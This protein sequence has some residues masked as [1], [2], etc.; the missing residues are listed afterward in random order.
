MSGFLSKIRSA[1]ADGVS[2]RL[3]YAQIYHLY[4]LDF[5]L[6]YLCSLLKI[7]R[8]IPMVLFGSFYSKFHVGTTWLSSLF[9]RSLGSCLPYSAGFAGSQNCI[10]CTPCLFSSF[11]WYPKRLITSCVGSGLLLSKYHKNGAWL[12]CWCLLFSAPLKSYVWGLLLNLTHD[13][14]CSVSSSVCGL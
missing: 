12:F 10:I 7:Q 5:F 13:F 4:S 1:P 14:L 3:S 6:K 11:L 9:P 2:A 8:L